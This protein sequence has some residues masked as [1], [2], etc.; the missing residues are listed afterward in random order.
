MQPPP[1]PIGTLADHM[2]RHWLTLFCGDFGCGYS[3]RFD[4]ADLAEQLG[5]T[6]PLARLVRR[7]VCS[8]CGHKGARL[9]IAPA[10]LVDGRDGPRRG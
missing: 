7:S 2:G 9:Q 1:D 8:R 10:H 6:Y 5:A 4:P 3:R